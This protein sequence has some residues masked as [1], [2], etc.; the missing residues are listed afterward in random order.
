M[1]EEK[2]QSKSKKDYIENIEVGVLIAFKIQDR[3]VSAKVIQVNENDVKVET[4][5]GS[6]YFVGKE[7]IAWVKTGNRWP[8]GIYNALCN[9]MTNE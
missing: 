4:K 9:K 8:A 5:N 7:S 2:I 6:I 3:M 1:E